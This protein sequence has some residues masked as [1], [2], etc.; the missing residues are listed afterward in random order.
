MQQII[1]GEFRFGWLLP[2][3]NVIN[4]EKVVYDNIEVG[5]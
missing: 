3:E 1:F 4:K 5:G 2:F